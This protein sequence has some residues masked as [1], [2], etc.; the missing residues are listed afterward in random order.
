MTAFTGAYAADEVD[1]LAS[2][3][4]RGTIALDIGA[5]LGLY[6]V[7]LAERAR[8]LD[9]YVVAVEPV[10]ANAAIVR[11]NLA[12]NGLDDRAS[13]VEVALGAHEGSLAMLV[14]EGGAGNATASSGVARDDL[15]RHV[16]EGRLGPTVE[17][18]MQCLDTLPFDRAVSVVK[19]DAEGFEMDILAGGE[20]F[21]ARH[22][23]V[24][25]GEFSEPWMRSRGR[26]LEEP[27]EWAREHGYTVFNVFLE[28]S[29]AIRKRTWLRVAPIESPAER[30]PAE[31]LLVPVSS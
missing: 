29:G 8:E 1:L 19:I 13:V 9:A 31:L 3:L 12:A 16:R 4:R 25:F 15:A 28:R 17:A 5:S 6:T 24:I 26:R 14:E 23:P 11:A 20:S 30:K 18:P 2:H 21:V 10:P 7:Q 22:R 27:F